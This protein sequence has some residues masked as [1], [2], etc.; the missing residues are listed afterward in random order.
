MKDEK[1]IVYEFGGFEL[2]AGRRLLRRGTG[3]PI[4]LTPKVFDTLLYLVEHRGETLDKDLLLR[5]IW[6]ELVVEENNLTQNIS[7]L[8]QVLGEAR[9]ENRFIATVPRKGY[10]FVAEVV[11]RD[12]HTE[13]LAA[14]P[15][16]NA[17]SSAAAPVLP[18]I[19]RPRRAL[20]IGLALLVAMIG[21]G[22]LLSRRDGTPVEAPRI[23]AIGGTQDDAAYLLY[24][25]GRYALSRNAEASLQL[26]IDY[27]QQAIARDPRFALAHSHLAEAYVSLGIF[28]MRA[29]ADTFPRA[30]DSVLEALRIEPRLATAYATLGHIKLQFDRDWEGAGADFARAIELD[31]KLPEPHLYLGALFVMRG[32][33]ER[34]LDEIRQAQELEPLLTLFKTRTGSMYYFA[35]RYADAEKQLTESVAL[36]EHFSIAHRAL[37]RVYLHT[38]RY[39]LALA[40]FA[41]APGISP[42]SYAD[43]ADVYALS[44]RRA[45]AQAEL[46]RVLEVARGRYV[47][48]VDIAAIYAG[49]G[50]A[51]NATMWLDK[52]IEQR[53]ST[54]GFVAQNPIF[55]SLHSDPRFIAIVERIGVWKKPLLPAPR[56]TTG[57]A[58]PT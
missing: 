58:A 33:L 32:E 19:A 13:A 51:D 6:P 52:A 27:F 34:G 37:G 24:T 40:E 43:V 30:R 38:G 4:A 35:R 53:A 46:A 11:Q 57:P 16:R 29:P 49:L 26:A 22:M 10:R 41:K 21:A 28:G 56:R 2:E 8:R 18:I 7:T 20:W 39:E 3:E 1:R 36:D 45:E 42:G 44:G 9:G 15:E 12:L 47:S 55:D 14:T 25:Q 23:A 31:P 54:L 50:D 5:A 17:A 48:A